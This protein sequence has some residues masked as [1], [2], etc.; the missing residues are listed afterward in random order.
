[1]GSVQIPLLTLLTNSGK[2]DFNFRLNRPVV[3]PN[4]RVLDQEIYYMK[5][6]DLIKYR[7][8][9]HEQVPTYLNLSISLEPNIELPNE[10]IEYCYPGAGDQKLLDDGT[11]W[12][13]EQNSK[14][15]FKNSHIRI[16]GENLAGVSVLLCRFL[17]P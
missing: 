13:H 11:K 1:M 5:S 3:L 4:Y 14:C 7:A 17:T 10:N 8:M 2:T 15:R 16:F 9:E 12:L 6:D